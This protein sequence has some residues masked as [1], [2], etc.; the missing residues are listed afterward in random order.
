MMT[1]SERIGFL[2]KEIL[3]AKLYDKDGNRRTNT[4]IIGMLLSRCAIQDVFIQDQ[5]L[6][7][8]FSAWQNEQI[9]QEN[10]ELEN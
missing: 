3:L 5:K 4:Q 2:R 1:V 9:I 7:N 8:E 6:E 10:L